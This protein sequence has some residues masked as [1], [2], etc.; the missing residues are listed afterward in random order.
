M[1]AIRYAGV[2]RYRA[3]AVQDGVLMERC[4]EI[5]VIL[6]ELSR[7]EA[8]VTHSVRIALQRRAYEQMRKIDPTVSR[9]LATA[10]SE[11]N[12]AR[13]AGVSGYVTIKE[14]LDLCIRYGNVCVACGQKNGALGM[15]HI[16]PLSRNGTHTIDNIQP[17]CFPCNRSKF[18]KTL[19]YRGTD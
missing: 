3:Q 7:A 14:W 11:N 19:N 16:V 18:T 2:N 10:T 8:G 4:D 5:R 15:D 13:Y 9:D 6:D 1:K 17:M 12:R